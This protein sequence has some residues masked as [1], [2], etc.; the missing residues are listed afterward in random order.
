MSNDK[1]LPL[2]SNPSVP[3]FSLTGQW[4]TDPH[5]L[6]LASYLNQYI[7]SA[8]KNK[9]SS[10]AITTP[11]KKKGKEEVARNRSN[12]ELDPCCYSITC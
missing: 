6:T 9:K 10:K 11:R 2:A 1:T 4:N 3:S 12:H 7:S 8:K 5:T